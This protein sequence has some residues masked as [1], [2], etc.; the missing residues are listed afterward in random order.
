M[1]N[2]IKVKQSPEY[3][4]KNDSVTLRELN[5]EILNRGILKACSYVGVKKEN[6][7][8]GVE[9]KLIQEFIIQD[10]GGY[11]AN[12]WDLAFKYVAKGKIKIDNHFNNFSCKYIATVLNGY[13]EYLR[14]NNINVIKKIEEKPISKTEQDERNIKAKYNFLNI[15]CENLETQKPPDLLPINFLY[16]LL[17]ELGLLEELSKD[18]KIKIWDEELKKYKQVCNHSNIRYDKNYKEFIKAPNDQE[19]YYYKQLVT[20]IKKKRYKS[21]LLK[22]KNINLE[23]FK[24]Q[25]IEKLD[26][27]YK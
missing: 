3:R 14:S 18:E 5:N 20:Q 7:P 24:K 9:L 23:E 1:S 13:T 15:I 11:T 17:N 4:A 16:D 21:F 10:L 19:N 8:T 6:I 22:N 25:A 12:E 26:G 27:Y 2:L